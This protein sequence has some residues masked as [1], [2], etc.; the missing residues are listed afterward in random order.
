MHL[1]QNLLLVE[2]AYN[3]SLH[4][5]TLANFSRKPQNSCY[6]ESLSAA[7]GGAELRAPPKAL[8][9]LQHCRSPNTEERPGPSPRHLPL[10]VP[11]LY[12]KSSLHSRQ[13]C[14]GIT[15]S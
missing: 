6:S 10:L 14:G 12:C 7:G 15:L 3:D 5:S 1:P 13:F 4:P 8:S 11:D 2:V 9:T